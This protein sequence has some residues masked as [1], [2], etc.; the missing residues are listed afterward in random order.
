VQAG[1]LLHGDE[2]GLALVPAEK[3]ESI[4][5]MVA[6]VRAREGKLLDY[7]RGESFTLEGL[8]AHILE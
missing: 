4:P 2:N 6:R 7:V 3:R 1:D 8:K 5:E